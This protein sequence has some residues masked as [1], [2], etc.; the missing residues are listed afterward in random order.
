MKKLF[1]LIT[2]AAALFMSTTAMAAESIEKTIETGVKNFQTTIDV[3]K[4]DASVSQVMKTFSDMFN[5]NPAMTNLDGKINCTYKGT[6]A[7]TITV[8][9]LETKDA[10]AKA[11]AVLNSIVSEASKKVNPYDEIK[12]VHDEL[13]RR[14]NYDYTYK[15]VTEYDLLV[16]GKGTCVAYSL[17]FKSAMDKLNIPCTVAVEKDNSHSWDQVNVNGKWYNI[18]VTYDENYTNS[19]NADQT[20]F[21]KSDNS[22]KLVQH[23]NWVSPNK[24][25]ADYVMV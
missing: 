4:C 1:A 18:D 22:F 2:I 16:D 12:Y 6:K 24:C 15:G 3:S 9:Y 13:I 7:Q 25:D 23:H 8:G 14:A 19:A 17:A 20:F 21:L 11:D 5:T 10:A